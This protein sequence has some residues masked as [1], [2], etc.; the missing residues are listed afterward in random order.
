M[1]ICRVTQALYP[2]VVGGSPIH[3][4]ELSNFQSSKGHKVTVLTPKRETKIENCKIKYKLKQFFWYKMP[5]DFLG[6]ENPFSPKLWYSLLKEDF[7]ILHA[8]SHLFF[9]TFFS[10][11]IAKMKKKPAIVT[12]HGVRAV[13][14][15]ATNFFQEIWLNLFS[16][17]IFKIADK[18]ICLTNE[19]AKE[20][21]KYGA[22]DK[23]IIVLSNGIDTD[24]FKPSDK[25]NNSVLWIG[26][27]VEEKGLKYLV[28]ASVDL[29]DKHKDI[30]FVLVG[31]GPLKDQ[32]K[33]LTKELNLFDH[34]MFL[35]F[36]PQS[37]IAELMKSCGVFVLPSL[38][39]GFPKSILEAM[40]C[41]KPIITTNGLA[42]IVQ[43][44][45]IIV[46]E[47]NSKELT[48]AI[49]ILITNSSERIKRGKVG[50]KYVKD[51]WS[52]DILEEKIADVY[53]SV[54]RF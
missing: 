47:E 40:A 34:F 14:D 17:Y 31:D 13:R 27:F 35:D 26:R 52:W 45:G 15:T 20:I 50:R 19:D 42:E 33:N 3:C 4:H 54:L 36:V 1:K 21:K 37:N 7:D 18:I 30:E 22:G 16:R 44:C 28:D 53:E 2:Y 6:M 51:R 23:D 10:V 48:K 25:N 38:Q 12:I 11:I 32:I 24:L 41:A 9:T 49:D 46:E 39:E 43:D 29:I 5:W 8:H